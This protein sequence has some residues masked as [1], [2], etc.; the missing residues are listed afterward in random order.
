MQTDA[1]M[2][3]ASFIKIFVS[4]NANSHLS[5][6]ADVFC[7]L[8]FVFHLEN[9]LLGSREIYVSHYEPLEHDSV[10]FFIVIS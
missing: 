7:L 9:C 4:Y 3:V 1:M 8:G 5:E 10:L 6:G 2:T